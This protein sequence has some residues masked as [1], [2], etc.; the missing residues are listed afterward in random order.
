[1]NNVSLEDGV[2]EKRFIENLGKWDEFL[3]KTKSNEIL[4]VVLKGH[5]YIERELTN[6]LTETILDE[7][8][9]ENTTFRYKL[10][11]VYSMN[12]IT[13][14]Y[15]S[16]KKV[17]DIR[18]NYAHKFDYEFG[19]NEFNDLVSTLPKEGKKRF[20]DN[21]SKGMIKFDNSI[22]EFNFKTQLLLHKIW[23]DVI[24]SQSIAKKSLIIKMEEKEIEV[25]RKYT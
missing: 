10:E 15:G 1:M 4:V 25:N 24:V 14:Y 8:V 13:K 7:K 11:L 2:Q 16:I 3:A 18:N 5:M 20:L 9:L 17:N 12:L 23:L 19:E 6:L 22:P 21:Y